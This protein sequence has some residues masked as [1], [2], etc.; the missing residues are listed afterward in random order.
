MSSMRFSAR[1]DRSHHG[2][3]KDAGVVADVLTGIRNAMVKCLFVDNRVCMR[4]VFLGVPA[5]TN[6]EDSNLM[7][8]ETMQW[9]LFYL[10]IGH[11]RPM[12][13][14]ALQEEQQTLYRHT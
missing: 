14:T 4:K 10:S 11:D 2:P 12:W 5:G 3:F 1:L 8:L 7:S 6:P 9:V 13:T